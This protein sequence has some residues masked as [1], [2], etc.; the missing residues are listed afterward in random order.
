MRNKEEYIAH[1]K[2]LIKE[3][4]PDLCPDET[5]KDAYNEITVKLN[6][7]L[8]QLDNSVDKIPKKE[9]WPF[10]IFSFRYYFGKILAIGIGKNSLTNMDFL[11]F[12]NFLISEIKKNDEKIAGYFSILLSD[13]SIKKK[14]IKLLA[15]ACASYNSIFQNYYEYS[16]YVVKESKI[17]SDSFFS[18]YIKASDLAG[19]DTMIHEVKEWLQ[20][21]VEMFYEHLPSHTIHQ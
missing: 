14:S 11:I 12:R 17:I 4:Q 9:S 10:N 8:Y 13:D 3:Y 19:I 18:D 5:L 20:R 15:E 1:I 7:T 2:H 6:I 21:I 16:D